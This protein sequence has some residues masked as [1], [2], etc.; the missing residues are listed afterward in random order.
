MTGK[1]NGNLGWRDLSPVFLFATDFVEIGK[2]KYHGIYSHPRRVAGDVV[3]RHLVDME[4]GELFFPP[5]PLWLR[6]NDC[7]SIATDSTFKR[8]EGSFDDQDVTKLLHK[9]QR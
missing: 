9:K 1:K 4:A 8:Q 5:R 6:Q 7:R 2:N 3:A